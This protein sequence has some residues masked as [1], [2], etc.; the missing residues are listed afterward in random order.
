M[1]SGNGTSTRSIPIPIFNRA[2]VALAHRHSNLLLAPGE[3]FG[4]EAVQ[5][6]NGIPYGERFINLMK[7]C[8]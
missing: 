4:I 3:V 8:I 1:P 5:G 2:L 6:D 7:C